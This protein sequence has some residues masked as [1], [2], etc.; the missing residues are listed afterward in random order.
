MSW[1]Y[2]IV[3]ALALVLAGALYVWLRW[4]RSPQAY[5]AMMV[6]AA[7]YFVAG[8]L[9]GAW[10][11]RLAAPVSSAHETVEPPAAEPPRAETLP[12]PPIP[13]WVEPPR[14]EPAGLPTEAGRIVVEGAPLSDEETE[15]LR[16][17]C[18]DHRDAS[19]SARDFINESTEIEATLQTYPAE[20]G[21]AELTDHPL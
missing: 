11:L 17:F 20:S 10:A 6:L 9:A 2:A 13:T 14:S 3:A 4:R 16:R 7:C 19:V 18:V 1:T 15:V 8:A 5:R 12:N 21:S